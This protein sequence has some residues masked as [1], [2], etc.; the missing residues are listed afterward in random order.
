MQVI[1]EG[2][3]RILIPDKG[4]KLVHK[5]SGHSMNKVYLCIVDSPDNYT[6]MVDEKYVP[7]D[8][9]VDF[10][11][12]KDETNESIDI[13]AAAIDEMF[14]MFEPLMV[15][16]LS[17]TDEVNPMAKLY[18]MMIQRGLKQIDDIPERYREQVRNLL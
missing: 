15:M 16:T 4:Y 18:L 12:F 1:N 6:E 2:K 8:Y 17:D 5:E 3:L 10:T 9:I 11:E 14:M 7:M 13:I